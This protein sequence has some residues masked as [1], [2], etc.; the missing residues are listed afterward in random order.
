MKNITLDVGG[1]VGAISGY[2]TPEIRATPRSAELSSY[3]VMS[4][5]K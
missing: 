1:L 4:C 5:I 2:L 3:T